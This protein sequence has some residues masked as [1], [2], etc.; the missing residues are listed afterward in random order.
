MATRICAAGCF[1]SVLAALALPCSALASPITDVRVN[2]SD[3]SGGTSSALLDK[4]A[5]SMRI[6][7]EQL[8]ADRDSAAVLSDRE[9]Y[10]RLLGEIADRVITGYQA[11]DVSLSVIDKGSSSTAR[12]DFGVVPWSQ[13]V[14]DAKVEVSF[15]GISEEAAFFL[16]EKIPTLQSDIESTLEGASLDATDWASGVVRGLVRDEV[17]KSLPDFRA[18]VDVTVKD[19]D[20]Q[21]QVVV[22]PVGDLVRDVTYSMDSRTIPNLLLMQLKY[23]YADKVKAM[24]GLPVSYV[25]ENSDTLKAGILDSLRHEKEVRRYNLRPEMTIR[26]GA[27]TQVDIALE[28]HNYRIWLEGYGDIGRDD[29]NLSGRAHFGKFFARHSEIFGEVGVELK[30]VDWDFSGGYAYHKGK[31]QVA[32]MRRAPSAENVWR[33]EYD[34]TPKWR[35]RYEHFSGSGVSEWAVRYRIHEF[36]S[37][38]YVFSTDKSYFRVVGNL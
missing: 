11:S 15:S 20:A 32:Y 4:M 35:L 6:V 13:R 14:R 21:V 12:V 29:H 16:R 2:V 25:K 38:E 22:Y 36:L 27:D 24:R 30:D 26:P 9:G 3:A 23:R 17:E 18:A 8:F 5:S 1:L 19:G 31:A 7:S 34:F 33:V 10:E 28:S 37:G